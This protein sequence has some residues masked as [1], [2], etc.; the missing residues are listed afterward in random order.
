VNGFKAQ[1]VIIGCMA[2]T[3]VI[4]AGDAI[5]EDHMFTFRQGVGFM[6]VSFGLATGALFAPELAASMAVLTLTSAVFLYGQPLLD[7]VT[8]VTG[9]TTTK[10]GK[11][12]TTTTTTK[13]VNA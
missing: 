12:A 4:A 3:G 1:G 10:A 7:A 6:F 9:G 5:A 13:V 2:A 8:T 11:T